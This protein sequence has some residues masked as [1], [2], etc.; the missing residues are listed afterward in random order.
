MGYIGFRVWGYIG[1]VERKWKLLFTIGDRAL[2][3]PAR[4]K[5]NF[6]RNLATNEYSAVLVL[7]LIARLISYKTELPPSEPQSKLLKRGLYR[8]YIGDYYKGY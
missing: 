3:S 4:I 7:A 2:S 1:I 6:R 8:D 5:C